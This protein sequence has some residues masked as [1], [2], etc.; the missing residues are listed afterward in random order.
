MNVFGFPCKTPGCQAWLKVGD[1]PEDSA[2]SIH[3]PINLGDDPRRLL[4][5]DCGQAHNY[6][7]LE[8]ETR[9]WVQELRV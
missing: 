7:F 5:P 4:C 1:F 3:F 2:R 9:R 6:Y 8:K